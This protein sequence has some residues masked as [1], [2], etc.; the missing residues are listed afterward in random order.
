MFLFLPLTLCIHYILPFKFKN[1]FLFTVSVLFYA[2][3][4]GA[5]TLLILL[6]TLLIEFV[7]RLRL[8]MLLLSIINYCF[9]LFVLVFD[10]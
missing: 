4:E 6:S 7:L 8:S 10:F 2:W 1:L 5:L 9:D 3:G